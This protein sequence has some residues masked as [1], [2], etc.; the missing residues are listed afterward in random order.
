MEF[1]KSKIKIKKSG[2]SSQRLGNCERCDKFAS[3]IYCETKTNTYF[4]YQINKEINTEKYMTF[5]C[6]K[7]ITKN[8]EINK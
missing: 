6:E 1:L 8:E 2:S 4:V 3:E 7:C 5:V